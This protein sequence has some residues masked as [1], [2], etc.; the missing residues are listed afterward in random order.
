MS[1]PMEDVIGWLLGHADDDRLGAST[2]WLGTARPVRGQ[3]RGAG[4]DGPPV[5]ATDTEP[6]EPERSRCAG[7]R[8]WST[9]DTLKVFAK[10]APAT[11]FLANPKLDAVSATRSA[12]VA[13]VDAVCVQAARQIEAPAPP[14]RLS[15]ATDLAE[16]YLGRLDGSSFQGAGRLRPDARPVP[17]R[18]GRT[19]CRATPRAARGPTRP[20]QRRRCLAP[21]GPRPR[22]RQ[23]PA[24]DREGDR[25]TPEEADPGRTRRRPD[26]CR[27]AGAGTDPGRRRPARR[28]DPHRG[29]GM[30]DHVR[31]SAESWSMP[32][33][34]SR[35][36]ERAER[37]RPSLRRSPRSTANRQLSAARARTRDGGR[38]CSAMSS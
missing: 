27:T 11:V 4:M 3:S 31:R 8:S 16:A 20:S 13:A 26:A 29:R 34:S 14:P 24:A 5:C 23:R 17:R 12:L 35:S 25:V 38:C 9:S 6:R 33:S 10:A 2:R 32:A 21:A 28:G 37:P 19:G 7:T 1:A 36:R 30:G 15:S 22:S 18:V